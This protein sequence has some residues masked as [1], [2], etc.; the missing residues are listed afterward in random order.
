M[1]RPV[2]SPGSLEN[3]SNESRN[4][5]VHRPVRCYA[6]TFGP[7]VVFRGLS[8]APTAILNPHFLI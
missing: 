3:R 7:P 6:L 8:A 2:E 5:C 1:L 4:V